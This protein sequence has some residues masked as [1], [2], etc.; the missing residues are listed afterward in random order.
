MSSRVEISGL[1]GLPLIKP[2]DDLAGMIVE[3]AR[4]QGLGIKNG[5]IIVIGQ[6]AVSK[7]EGRLVDIAAVRPSQVA[8]DLAQKVRKKAGFVEVV[9]RDSKKV[10]RASR[11]ALSVTA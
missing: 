7:S 9:L 8:K 6:K 4:G 10:S 3:Q 11:Q 1:T 5:D 2:G